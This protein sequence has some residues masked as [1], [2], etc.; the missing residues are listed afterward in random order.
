[1]TQDQYTASRKLV[2][3]MM[4][5]IIDRCML[6]MVEESKSE[7]NS[8]DNNVITPTEN[9]SYKRAYTEFTAFEKLK[10]KN[11]CPS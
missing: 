2:V 11:T 5:D 10:R 9:A 1:M 8:R 3:S 6:V 4:H 7:N